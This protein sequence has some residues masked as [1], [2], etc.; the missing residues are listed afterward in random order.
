MQLD[1]D[2]GNTKITLHNHKQIGV[3]ISNRTIYR[4]QNLNF[5]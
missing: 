1:H 3:T 4:H 5:T 2:C